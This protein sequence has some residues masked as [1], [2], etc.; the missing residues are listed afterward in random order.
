MSL[1]RQGAE[2]VVIPE[3]T[4]G[5]S[6]MCRVRHWEREIVQRNLLL[7]AARFVSA[8]RFREVGGFDESITGFE[9]LD[10]QARLI[11]KNVA[12]TRAAIPLW[13]HEE[14]VTLRAYLGKRMY[15]QRSSRL[16][17]SKHPAFARQVFSI[18]NRLRMYATGVHSP[19][20]VLY[21][22][23]ATTLRFLETRQIGG[24]IR[25]R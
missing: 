4:L 3:K 2:A 14:G 21:A 15:Y 8:A 9:D 5:E 19:R 24:D 11:E 18:R 12:I 16:Y 6:F 13:H 22:C 17:A 20:Q 1:A 7:T 10:F 25:I 23:A